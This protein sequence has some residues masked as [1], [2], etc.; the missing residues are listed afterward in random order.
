MGLAS[1]PEPES[2]PEVAPI[3]PAAAPVPEPDPEPD[4]SEAAGGVAPPDEHDVPPPEAEPVADTPIEAPAEKPV[5]P[6]KH[7]NEARDSA[8]KIQLP[9]DIGDRHSVTYTSLLA[10][11]INPLGLEERLWIG[12]QYRLYDKTGDIWKG[13]NIGIFLRPI[14]SPAIGLIGPTLQIQPLAVLRLRA[15]WS[16][17]GWLGTFDYMQSYQSPWDD[18]SDTRLDEQTAKGENY[19]TFGHQTELELLFQVR[20]KQIVLRNTL[21]ADYNVMKLRGN[22]DVYYDIRIDALVPNN[23]WAIFNDTDLL[24]AQDFK[25]PRKST[26]LVGT[27]ATVVK[28]FYPK[29]VYEKG[30][31]ISDPNGPIFKLGPELGYIFYDRPDKRPRFNRPTLLLIPQWNILHRWRSGRDVAVGY[32]T[33]T[34]AF[35]FTGQLWGKNGK[36][37]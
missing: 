4:P 9:V 3:E 25:G 32:P 2:K 29:H 28:A 17:V 7:D 18:F 36:T 21:T 10:P 30:D 24:W 6:K 23:G 12:Y 8:D 16:F 31:Q 27:R 11:R 20:F 1:P 14:L 33:I 5:D 26:L 34:L 15:T 13:S 37:K 35:V 22:D 19:A